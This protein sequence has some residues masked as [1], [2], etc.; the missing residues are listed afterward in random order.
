MPANTETSQRICSINSCGR[1]IL[2]IIFTSCPLQVS[3]S[4]LALFFSPLDTCL[5]LSLCLLLSRSFFLPSCYLSSSLLLHHFFIT[6]LFASISLSFT[7]FSFLS[8][9]TL[10]II[11]SSVCLWL[12]SPAFY[13]PFE[14]SR[15]RPQK[16]WHI[17][18][19][20]LIVSLSCIFMLFPFLTV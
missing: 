19:N 3:F 12:S 17:H 9:L 7:S 5:S 18:L 4:F 11:S 8:L 10:L 14:S 6:F 2:C 20:F 1:N 15:L 16:V 13:R